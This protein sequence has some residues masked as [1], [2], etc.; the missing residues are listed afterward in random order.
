MSVELLESVQYES[1]SG[2]FPGDWVCVCAASSHFC[3]YWEGLIMKMYI[4]NYKGPLCSN[5]RWNLMYA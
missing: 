4:L 1:G 5:G 2:V 3:G